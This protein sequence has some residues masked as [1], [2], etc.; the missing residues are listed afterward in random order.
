MALRI[1]S[2]TPNAVFTITTEPAWPALQFQTNASL[3]PGQKLTWSWKIQWDRFSKQGKE[4]TTTSSWNAQSVLFQTLTA[5]VITNLGGNLAVQV[6]GPGGS[7]HCPVRIKGTN[8]TAAEVTQ[9][10]ASQPNSTGFDLILNH[11]SH[12][13]HFNAHGEPIKSFDHG[14][15]MSQLTNPPPTYEQAWNWK[16]N[17]AA[18]LTLFQAKQASAIAYLSQNNRTYT[19]DQLI[20]ETICRW[21]GGSYHVWNGQAWVR[22]TNILCDSRTGNIG[23]DLN[24]SANTGQTEAQLHSRDSGSYGSPPGASAHWRYFGVCYADQLMP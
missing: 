3:S 6:T 9:F 10:L 18:G 12:M 13:K 5:G 4:Q 7:A 22:P 1:T 24:N 8:P 2:P 16:L 15:G 14:Y 20:R 19:Q 23:W 11:E 17:I 21:N